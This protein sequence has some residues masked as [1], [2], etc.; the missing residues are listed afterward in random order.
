MKHPLISVIVTTRNNHETLE[1]CLQSIADQSYDMIELIV[2]DNNSSDDTKD[3]AHRF[4]KH[5]YNKGPERSAQ[6]NYAVQKATGDY[7][8]II[9]SDMVLSS[10][11]IA[12]CAETVAADADLRALIIP[13]ESFGVG[14]W[15]QCKKL[16]RSFYVGVDWIEAARFFDKKTYLEVGGYNENMTGGEDWDFTRRMR[17]AVSVGRSK[18]FIYHNEGHIYFGK[19]MRKMYYY[20]SNA[21][22]YFAVNDDQSA[23][24]DKSGPLARYQL[25][26]SQPGKLFRNP[27]YGL[28]ALTLKTGEFAAGA[29][30]LAKSR[31]RKQKVVA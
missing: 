1:A 28:G 15:A 20:A 30:G 23:L 17:R 5:V 3:I 10:D 22:A 24:T 6:R 14:F 21:G 18:A 25:F 29:A 12:S 4:T 11:V 7:V 2:V 19:T 31:L 9:D 16:E 26:L 27:F 13:E 8:C